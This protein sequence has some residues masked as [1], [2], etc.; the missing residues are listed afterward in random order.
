MYATENS[1]HTRVRSL[2]VSL[3]LKGDHTTALSASMIA[4]HFGACSP[5]ALSIGHHKFHARARDAD[6]ARPSRVVLIPPQLYARKLS[7]PCIAGAICSALSNRS[8]HKQRS[9][10]G[11]FKV[12]VSSPSPDPSLSQ[13]L[14]APGATRRGSGMGGHEHC[15]NT[16]QIQASR[17]SGRQLNGAHS[18]RSV[19]GIC[20]ER[21]RPGFR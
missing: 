15:G 3:R 1:H 5:A 20:C 8:L 19:P 2:I 14:N 11:A 17:G 9:K 6:S 13:K 7:P 4:S 16:H 12:M 18:F 21:S 10:P